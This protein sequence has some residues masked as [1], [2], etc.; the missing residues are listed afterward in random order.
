MAE[1]T[2]KNYRKASGII[3][4]RYSHS[5]IV[6]I[7]NA[8]KALGTSRSEYLRTKISNGQFRVHF[9]DNSYLRLVFELNKIGINL[10]QYLTRFTPGI[11]HPDVA[12]DVSDMIAELSALVGEIKKKLGNT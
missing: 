11:D 9:V 3:Q 4:I 5:E 8:A 12:R 6:A 1:K 10:N 2:K 7:D